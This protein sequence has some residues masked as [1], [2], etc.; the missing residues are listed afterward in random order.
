MRP[1]FKTLIV[2]DSS[3]FRKILKMNLIDRF[4]FI[5]IDEA[6]DGQEALKKLT[7]SVPDL[8]LMDIELPGTDGLELTKSIRAVHGNIN[9]VIL[10]S[11]SDHAHIEAAFECGADA[12]FTKGLSSLEKIATV[13]DTLMTSKR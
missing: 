13:V 1:P 12:F 8:I 5:A 9:I 10:T 2:E 4:P 6:A 3:N 11:H 7:A